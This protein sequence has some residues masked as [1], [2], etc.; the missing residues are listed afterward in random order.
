MEP[1][2]PRFTANYADDKPPVSLGGYLKYLILAAAVFLAAVFWTWI[3]SPMIVTVTGSGEVSVPATN[4]TVSYS[5]S[6]NDGSI[7]SAVTS[8]QAKA[9]SMRDFL[10]SKGVADSDIAQSQITAVPAGMVTPGAGGF[11]ATVTMAAKTVHVSSI[12]SLVSDLYTN[13]AVVVSQPVLSIENQDSL[14]QQAF[15]SALKD[16]KSQA[17]S[18]GNR[19]WKFIRKIVSVSQVSSPSTSTSTTKAD[20]LTGANSQIAAT[21]GVFKIVK[22][23][24]VSY[25]MW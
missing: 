15:D 5:L 8:V 25:K 23:V 18:I 4:A 22:A 20:T 14:E 9:D 12:S 6:S 7:Q 11:Q 24:S 1:T 3:S 17:S 19:N 13:G 21:N 10:K 16:A 2:Q